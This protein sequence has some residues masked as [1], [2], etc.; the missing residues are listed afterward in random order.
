[1]LLDK[2]DLT[3]IKTAYSVNIDSNIVS[4]LPQL[5][6]NKPIT[7]DFLNFLVY[8]KKNNLDLN[9]SP[10]LLEDSLNSSGMKNEAR[11]YECLLSFFS[12]SDLSLQQLYSLPIS[13]DVIA[14]NHAD[15]AWSQMKYSRFYERNDE[16]RVRSIYCFLLKVYIIEFGSKKSS[17]KK[18]IELVDFINTNLGI[19]LESAYWY[20]NKS[21]NCVLDFFQKIQP[22]AK[23]KLK[24]VEG[25]AWDL[26]HLWDIPTEMAV[27]SHTYNAIILQA[28]ATH[29]DALAQIAKLNPIVRI[30]FYQQE[31]QVKYKLSLSNFLHN[32]PIIDSI[33]DNQKQ[34]ECL[35]ETVDLIEL[36][37]QLEH[38]FLNTIK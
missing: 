5:L 8:I 33:I 10:Y 20:F 2:N 25:M 36:S 38:E 30:A 7:P 16:K 11:A 13:P 21:Y 6:K 3:A 24:K 35:C 19:Y 15:D 23:D 27:Q 32:D 9:I 18:L 28:F 14:F 29:D 17:R 34:R 12:F 1:M 37:T 22:G 4:M 26:F 31:A